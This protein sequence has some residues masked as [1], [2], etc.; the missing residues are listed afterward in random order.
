MLATGPERPETIQ[1]VRPVTL[2]DRLA[3][4]RYNRRDKRVGVFAVDFLLR[5]LREVPHQ[6]AMGMP[7]AQHP[8]R[9][10][11]TLAHCRQHVDIGTKG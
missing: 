2:S 1:Y 10:A 7:Y 4:R 6:P 3:A 11:A 9:R 5:L 8:G